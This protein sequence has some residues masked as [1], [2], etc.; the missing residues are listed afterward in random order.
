M[1]RRP[2]A[3]IVVVVFVGCFLDEA[4]GIGHSLIPSFI[5]IKRCKPTNQ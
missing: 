1:E 4:A 5:T 3:S 2:S